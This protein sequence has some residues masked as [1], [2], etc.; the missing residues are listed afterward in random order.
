M[1]VD[2]VEHEQLV[3][4]LCTNFISMRPS[5]VPYV[6]HDQGSGPVEKANPGSFLLYDG[7]FEKD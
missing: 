6:S 5:P 7:E 2:C 4:S 1:F 3:L